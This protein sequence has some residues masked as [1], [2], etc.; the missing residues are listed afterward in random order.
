MNWRYVKVGILLTVAMVTSATG[1]Y[2]DSSLIEKRD[3]SLK[4]IAACLRR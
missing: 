3:Q 2:S 4:G 1:S